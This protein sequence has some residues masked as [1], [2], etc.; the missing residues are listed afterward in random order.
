MTSTAR[1]RITHTLEEGG[2]IEPGLKKQTR[3]TEGS[4]Q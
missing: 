2:F 4:I 3:K 1:E